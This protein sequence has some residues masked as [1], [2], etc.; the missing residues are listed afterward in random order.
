[1]SDQLFEVPEQLSPRRKWMLAHN[2]TTVY[3]AELEDIDDPWCAF[4][5]GMDELSTHG[6][7]MEED[8]RLKYGQTENEAICELAKQQGWKLWNEECRPR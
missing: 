7:R 4:V 5:G 3:S 1:M 8:G 2:V 6:L